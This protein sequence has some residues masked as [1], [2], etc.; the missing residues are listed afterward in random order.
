MND[1]R[2]SRVAGGAQGAEP[3]L[4]VYRGTLRRGE[5]DG[6]IVGELVDQLGWRIELFGTRAA[7]GSYT[8]SGRVS[9]V[10]IPGPLRIPAIDG[11]PP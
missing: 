9:A 7:D 10:G 6:T 8:L 5:Q 1:E 2:P 4:T 3:G 11:E